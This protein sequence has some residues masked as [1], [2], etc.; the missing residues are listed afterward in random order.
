MPQPPHLWLPVSIRS[1]P[2]TLNPKGQNGHIIVIPDP[3]NADKVQLREILHKLNEQFG[4]NMTEA[5]VVRLMERR[6]AGLDKPLN[7]WELVNKAKKE[8]RWPPPCRD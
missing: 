1:K 4:Q 3:Y 5:E 7:F 2:V 6:F 8:G